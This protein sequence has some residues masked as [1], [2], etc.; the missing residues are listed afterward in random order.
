MKGF[1]T[2]I[3]RKKLN[4]FVRYLQLFGGLLLFL[5]LGYIFDRIQ[6]ESKDP[7]VSIK[8]DLNNPSIFFNS[9]RSPK[10]QKIASDIPTLNLLIAPQ[11]QRKLDLQKQSSL[12]VGIHIRKENDEVPAKIILNGNKLV[13][14]KLRLKGDWVDHFKNGYPSL[15][16]KVLKSKYLFGMKRFSLQR[17]ETRGGHAEVLLLKHIRRAGLLAPR[18]KLVNLMVNGHYKGIMMVEEHFTKELLESSGR[19]ASVIM[20]FDES[21]IWKQRYVNR[22][23]KQRSLIGGQID[24]THFVPLGGEK[25]GPGLVGG[26]L[27][28][29]FKVFD[30]NRAMQDD[31]LKADYL[32]ALGL[33][34]G[35]QSG[36]LETDQVFDMRKLAKFF[37]ITHAWVAEHNFYWTNLRFYFNPM[38]KLFELISFD[39]VVIYFPINRPTVY[40]DF[41]KLQSSQVFLKY[42]KAELEYIKSEILARRFFKYIL[43]DEKKLLQTYQDLKQPKSPY[44]LKRIIDRIN[45]IL[46]HFP[47]PILS[48]YI[49]TPEVQNR[50][51]DSSYIETFMFVFHIRDK[52]DNYLEIQNL[53]NK[54]INIQSISHVFEHISNQI[55]DKKITISKYS[56]AKIK[57]NSPNSGNIVVKASL[58]HRNRNRSFTAI[59]YAPITKHIHYRSPSLKHFLKRYSQ[60]TYRPKIGII[61][62]KGK[63]IFKDDLI[64]PRNIPLTIFESTQLIFK[65]RTRMII[66]GPLA[67]QG[68]STNKVQFS[69]FSKNEG[70]RGLLVLGSGNK[71]I[72]N[73]ATF[74]NIKKD[75]LDDW[76]ISGAITVNESNVII[77]QLYINHIETEDALNIVRSRFEIENIQIAN[78]MSDGIDIDFSKGSISN[79]DLMNI[80]GDGVDVGGGIV[81]I[82]NLN[83]KKA[84]DKGLSVGEKS[85]VEVF[86]INVDDSKIGIA[87]KDDST[88]KVVKGIFKNISDTVLMTYTKKSEFAPSKM[89]LEQGVFSDYN[90]LYYAQ[91]GS[92]LKI[93]NKI[94]STPTEI[95]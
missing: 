65:P 3:N 80:G 70:W 35:I 68:T 89:I 12:K 46:D 39:N 64:L 38:T 85:Q 69:A 71:I 37:A 13:K 94:V 50:I 95:P 9:F 34:R 17:I 8:A 11:H 52:S 27:I 22:L 43:H 93:N 6:L 92:F 45:Y 83:V 73:F 56:H 32:E 66:R 30:R 81:K 72:L 90:E 36:N 10:I 86:N 26:H 60:F 57:I 51:N 31:L 67:I 59:P 41:L 55:S 49:T 29:P 78:T 88:T 87:S 58:N 84:H 2:N 16:I 42:Y 15:R 62:K 19:R 4:I 21:Y 20:A 61:L 75:S 53:T 82:T 48:K 7:F 91:L 54:P 5:I 24:D 1:Q 14:I 74:D 25:K 18:T 44:R 40:P 77:N 47:K 63:W 76:N 79:C 23:E 28:N 33:L